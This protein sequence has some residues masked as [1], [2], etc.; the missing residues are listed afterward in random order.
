ML[1]CVGHFTFRLTLAKYYQWFSQ[2]SHRHIFGESLFGTTYLKGVVDVSNSS[3]SSRSDWTKSLSGSPAHIPPTF[4]PRAIPYCPDR[5]R[6]AV[7]N[8]RLLRPLRGAETVRREILSVEES[9]RSSRPPGE[10]RLSSPRRLSGRRRTFRS[11]H[12]TA[13]V[14]LKHGGN[15]NI[16]NNNNFNNYNNSNI[17]YGYFQRLYSNTSNCH[18]M[19]L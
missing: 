18:Q 16:W 1:C 13:P 6:K 4:A 7:R 8:F 15:N 14:G 12:V 19:E 3:T 10:G 5:N 17:Q 11:F 2:F 9:A